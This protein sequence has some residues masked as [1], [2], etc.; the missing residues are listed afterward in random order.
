MNRRPP[1]NRK[2]IKAESAV[3]Y[4]F[5]TLFDRPTCPLSHFSLSKPSRRAPMPFFYDAQFFHF[6]NKTNEPCYHSKFSSP[7]QKNN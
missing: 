2:T 3:D 5:D 4:C 7:P 6:A 1:S